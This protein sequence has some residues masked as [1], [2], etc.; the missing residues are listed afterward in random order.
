[1]IF[2]P[3][4]EILMTEPNNKNPQANL[5]IVKNP[6]L[7]G[8]LDT[9]ELQLPA[10][11]LDES[12]GTLYFS[13][14]KEDGTLRLYKKGSLLS[15]ESAGYNDP[16]VVVKVLVV[17]SSERFMVCLPITRQML[18]LGEYTEKVLAEAAWEHRR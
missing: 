3:P 16:E 9:T 4:K 14:Y 2:H 7:A 17:R 12:R 11:F 1:M 8:E 10:D 15:D 13:R 18:S 6:V 5:S